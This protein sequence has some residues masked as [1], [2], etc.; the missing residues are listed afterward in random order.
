[1][2]KESKI[3]VAGHQGLVG[4]AILNSLLENGYQNLITRTHK[5]LDLLDSKA[6][7][8]FFMEVQP[9]YV[10][11]AAAKVGGIIANNA[12]RAEF[13]YQNL[14]IQS[15]VIHQSYISNVKKLLF[16]GSTCIYPR[17]SPQPIKEEYLL[18]GELEYTN[19]PYSTAKIAGMKMC[20]S[21]NIQY[22]T[23]FLSVMPTNL[24]GPKDNFDLEASH[25]IPAI[26]RKVYLGKALEENDW[27]TIANDLNRRPI[28]GVDG[29]QNKNKL[30][31]I[32]DKYGVRYK[33]DQE[34]IHNNIRPVEIEI[35]GSGKPIREFLWSEDMA[36]ACIHIMQNVNFQDLVTDS[37]R[38]SKSNQPMRNTHINIGT[39]REISIAHLAEII[40]IIIK[41]KGTYY[42]NSSLPDGTPRKLTDVSKLKGLGWKYSVELDEGIYRLFNWYKSS[43]YN[44]INWK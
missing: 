25:V 28:E 42:Y 12:H 31:E 36:E 3:Y 17:N 1:M 40:K 4:S 18:T 38:K 41:F 23:N 33:Y 15:N 37:Y 14:M 30:K 24:Y 19:E 26:L 6:V 13:I 20:E 10:F 43:I 22:G 5:A 9:E 29:S 2:L 7:E 8:E 32:L 39:G 34:A 35:W 27:E 44:M 11:L 16:L 21:Y